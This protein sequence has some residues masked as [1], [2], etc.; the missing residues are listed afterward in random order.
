MEENK[1]TWDG[2]DETATPSENLI[3][4][5]ELRDDKVTPEIEAE[6]L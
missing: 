2:G 6:E 5:L 4:F 3:K 1:V